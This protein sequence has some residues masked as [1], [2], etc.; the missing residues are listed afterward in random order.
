MAR[1]GGRR[2]FG[3]SSRASWTKAETEL[4]P[5]SAGSGLEDLLLAQIRA[6]GLP[7]P[8]RQAKLVPGRKFLHD[9]VWREHR[10]AVEV[11][12]GIW[13]RKGAH[14]SG[15]GVTRDCEKAALALLEGFRTLPVTGEQVRSGDALRW[16]ERLIGRP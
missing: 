7:E 4:R 14:T 10:L 9:F 2:S 13:L 1:R 11:Q 6:V 12:G 5:A 3:R 15:Q 8:E 16:I